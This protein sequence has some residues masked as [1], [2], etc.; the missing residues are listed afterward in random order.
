LT[1]N[2][3]IV[4]RTSSPD[5]LAAALAA[6][7]RGG[8]ITPL[9]LDLDDPNISFDSWVGV[10]E[11]IARIRKASSWWIGDWYIFGGISYGE[12]RAAAAESVTG[13]SAHTL[14]TIVRTCMYVPKTRRRLD[15][16]F[17]LHTEVARLMPEEQT[18]WLQRAARGDGR[19]PWTREVLREAIKFDKGGEESSPQW[20]GA[21]QMRR[22]NDLERIAREIVSRAQPGDGQYVQVERHLIARLRAALGMEE[23]A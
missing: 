10:G 15:L 4:S 20:Q 12:D 2:I 8:A 6:L 11:V 3:T 16:P 1:G 14:A 22:S 13:L 19:N 9:S 5:E 17:S 7:E 18:L 21:I 23:A